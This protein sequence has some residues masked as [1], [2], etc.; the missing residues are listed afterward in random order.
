MKN[1]KL[2]VG[3]FLM[4]VI[5]ASCTTSNRVTDG[6]FVQKRKYNKGFHINSTSRV[7]AKE[8]TVN[9]DLAITEQAL[10]EAQVEEVA[11][12]KVQEKVANLSYT[13]NQELI[14]PNKENYVST[15]EIVAANTKIIE[16]SNLETK[17]AKQE[18][19]NQ[20]RF[21]KNL[22]KSLRYASPVATSGGDN[23]LV[24]LLLC[25]FVGVIGI[26]RFYLGYIG[27]GVIQ[28]LTGGGCGIWTLIDLIR[29]ITGDLQPNGGRYSK[30][31]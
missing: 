27:I 2:F 22:L 8:T 17:A 7:K 21:D 12:P 23:Q 18:F 13:S 1:F 31:L 24:A 14:V 15:E 20:K 16:K 6:R 25:I 4:I 30:T 9:Y 3:V 29:I 11:K 19:K 5:F 26:H 28:L 10:V